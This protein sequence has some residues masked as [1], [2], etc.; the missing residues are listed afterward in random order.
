METIEINNFTDLNSG[1]NSYQSASIS[2]FEGCLEYE[3]LSRNK[4]LEYIDY[5]NLSAAVK[6]LGEFFDVNAAVITK[7]SLIC[8]AALGANG[9]TALEKA[10][11]CD[12]ISISGGT[13]GFSNEVS[14]EAAKLLSV[15]KIKNII[16]PKFSKDAFSY[17]LDTNINIIKLDTPLHELLGFDAKDIKVTPFG[18]LVQEQNNSKLS[19]ETFNVVS[20]TKPTQQQAEDGIFGWKISKHLTSK[21]AIIAKDLSTKAIIQGKTNGAAATES[22]MDL[23]CENSK[24]A[25]LIVDGVIDN[26]EIINAAAQGRIGLIIEA[27]DGENSSKILKLADKYELSMIHTKIRNN[28]Y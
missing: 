15:L 18:I 24:D 10:I 8:S 19:K 4:D 16:A 7:E 13:V 26:N 1:A 22:A 14:F 12:P 25:V 3:I 5:L 23:A 9:D 21:S 28:K 11:D 17:L 20:K 27:G 2:K 6:V